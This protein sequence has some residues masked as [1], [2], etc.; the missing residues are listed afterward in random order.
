LD[1]LEREEFFR[2]KK[3]QV[4]SGVG[5][6]VYGSGFETEG[7]VWFRVECVKSWLKCVVQG[8]GVIEHK[9]RE[10]FLSNFSGQLFRMAQGQKSCS[11]KLLRVLRSPFSVLI[12]DNLPPRGS[13]LG[14]SIGY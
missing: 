1:E 5:C 14:L 7:L 4:R 8:R 12:L 6:R 2:L 3:V 11:E 13:C 10:D 9:H